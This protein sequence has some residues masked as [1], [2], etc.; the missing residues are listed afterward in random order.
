MNKYIK[1]TGKQYFFVQLSVTLFLLHL[2]MIN[3]TII[4]IYYEIFNVYLRF[5]S[6]IY[7]NIE[8]CI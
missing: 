8:K 4:Y 6:E 7:Y 1:F 5:F 3:I 2:I